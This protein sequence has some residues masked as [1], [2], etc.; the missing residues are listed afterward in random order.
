MTLRPQFSL[1]SLSVGVVLT[2]IAAAVGIFATRLG[3][4]ITP[5]S[6][7]YLDLRGYGAG[8]A[9]FAPMYTWV[10]T[11]LGA[12]NDI[13]VSARALA[14]GLLAANILLAWFIV[15]S[16]SKSWIASAL[17]GLLLLSA[18]PYVEAHLYALSEGL[19]IL[20]T[21]FALGLLTKFVQR[22]SPFL[23][24]AAASA[25]AAALLTRFAGLPLVGA[26]SVAILLLRRTSLLRKSTESALFALVSTVPLVV[27]LIYSHS[28]GRGGTGRQ[29]AM[30][31]H[32]SADTFRDGIRALGNLLVPSELS[33]GAGVM[34]LI[35]LLG[36]FA[37]QTCVYARMMLSNR[38]RRNSDSQPSTL[39]YV[40]L[41]YAVSYL[42]FLVL[43][44]LV[45]ADLPLNV[46]YM[47]PAFAVLAP[48]GALL[49]WR[50]YG[51]GA[52]RKWL[53][54][55]VGALVL[56]LIAS[57]S[58][59]TLIWAVEARSQGLGYA[60]IS[61]RQSPTVRKVKELDLAAPIY[62]NGADAILVLTGRKA[63]S[64]PEKLHRLSGKKPSAEVFKAQMEAVGADL[65]VNGGVIVLFDQIDWR[66]YLPSEKELLTELP[67][68]LTANLEDGRIYAA[69]K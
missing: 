52:G 4:G 7:S 45:E 33:F 17:A 16:E 8:H 24:L 11:F 63:K 57:Q 62:S 38:A 64:L 66:Y 36:A 30:L 40:F 23:L 42:A 29:F 53:R 21:V 28:V 15:H 32:P 6:I 43:S 41:L 59:R 1:R 55:L 14:V 54:P 46:R 12:K 9:G 47:V 58:A 19:F 51:E 61:W 22:G 2:V 39:S 25:A 18:R 3:V 49:L 20:C 67:L 65:L 50:I 27:W 37:V 60:S 48:A 10:V 44:V 56:M 68:Q 13:L 69:A 26:G 34:L 5:D 35:L 31:G